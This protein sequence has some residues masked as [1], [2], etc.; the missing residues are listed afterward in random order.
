MY[1]RDDVVVKEGRTV[2][3]A[4]QFTFTIKNADVMPTNSSIQYY[5][6]FE[7]ENGTMHSSTFTIGYQY[8]PGFQ[9]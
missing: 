9:D 3:S 7:T 2:I 5:I 6:A 8:P 4:N 1:Y